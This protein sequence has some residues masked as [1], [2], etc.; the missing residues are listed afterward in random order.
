MSQATRGYPISSGSVPRGGYPISS[1]GVFNPYFDDEEE[2]D[3]AQQ[4]LRSRGII[5]DV[6]SDAPQESIWDRPASQY[7]RDI[8]DKYTEREPDDIWPTRFVK[9]FGREVEREV[10]NPLGAGLMGAAA[11]IPIAGKLGAAAKLSPGILRALKTAGKAAGPIFG[12]I[13]ITQA[14][15][16]YRQTKDVFESGFNPEETAE[17]VIPLVE[18]LGGAYLLRRAFKNRGLVDDPDDVVEQILKTSDEGT[19]VASTGTNTL[20]IRAIT[21]KYHDEISPVI[22]R[23]VDNVIPAGTGQLDILR[24][25]AIEVG[26][27][28]VFRGKGGGK[29]PTEDYINLMGQAVDNRARQVIKEARDAGMDIDESPENLLRAYN[30]ILKTKREELLDLKPTWK[31]DRMTAATVDKKQDIEIDHVKPPETTVGDVVDGTIARVTGIVKDPQSNT[32]ADRLLRRALQFKMIAHFTDTGRMPN[33]ELVKRMA[34]RIQ[35]RASNHDDYIEGL[36]K[37]IDYQ[38]FDEVMPYKPEKLPDDYDKPHMTEPLVP[39]RSLIRDETMDYVAKQW[40]GKGNAGDMLIKQIAEVEAQYHFDTKGV[41]P[42]NI[43]EYMRENIKIPKGSDS[44]ITFSHILDAENK[45]QFFE[46]AGGGILGKIFSN[47]KAKLLNQRKSSDVGFYPSPIPYNLD[48]L[49]LTSFPVKAR[50]LVKETL[51]VA[52]TRANIEPLKKGQTR[53]DLLNLAVRNTLKQIKGKSFRGIGQVRNSLNNFVNKRREELIENAP[54]W[55]PVKV[56]YTPKGDLINVYIPEAKAMEVFAYK[57]PSGKTLDYSSGYKRYEDNYKQLIDYTKYLSTGTGVSAARLREYAAKIRQ[58]MAVVRTA[59]EKGL[60]GRH[61]A[62]TVLDHLNNRIEAGILRSRIAKE[63]VDRKGRPK[64]YNPGRYDPEGEGRRI[65][66]SVMQ[67]FEQTRLE[68]TYELELKSLMDNPDLTMAEKYKAKF[69]LEQKLIRNLRSNEI[70]PT[71]EFFFSKISPLSKYTLLNDQLSRI[72]MMAQDRG[73]Y[74]GD[75]DIEGDLKL[76]IDRLQ[77]EIDKGHIKHAEE[78][79]QISADSIEGNKLAND[80]RQELDAIQRELGEIDPVMSQSWTNMEEG[81]GTDIVT[82]TKKT[83]DDI[84]A[85]GDVDFSDKDEI[86]TPEA[87]KALREVVDEVLSDA[88]IYGRGQHKWNV[89]ERIYGLTPKTSGKGAALR[90]ERRKELIAYRK[91]WTAYEASQSRKLERINKRL[92]DLR[93]GMAVSN[94][95]EK[96]R[97]PIDKLMKEGKIVYENMR[98]ARE[99]Y[100][101]IEKRQKAVDYEIEEM[102]KKNPNVSF[103]EMYMG[104]PITKIPLSGLFSPERSVKRLMSLVGGAFQGAY[105]LRNINGENLRELIYR[106]Y[107]MYTLFTSRGIAHVDRVLSG[108]GRKEADR[109]VRELGTYD[110]NQMGDEAKQLFALIQNYDENAATYAVNPGLLIKFD[111]DVS[112]GGF[113]DTSARE[114]L[115]DW[116]NIRAKQ[117]SRAKHFGNGGRNDL[118]YL[119]RNSPLGKAMADTDNEEVARSITES[120]FVTRDNDYG[121]AKKVDTLNT[122]QFLSYLSLHWIGNLAGNINTLMHAR[123]ALKGAAKVMFDRKM[124]GQEKGFKYRASRSGVIGDLHSTIG[125]EIWARKW[126]Q[127]S[128]KFIFLHHAESRER[129]WASAFGENTLETL[130]EMKKRGKLSEKA[131]RQLRDLTLEDPDNMTKLQEIHYIHARQRFAEITQGGNNPINMPPAWAGNN[132]LNLFAV[133]KRFAYQGQ[134]SF[135]KAIEQNPKRAIPMAL[136]ISPLFGEVI[137]DMKAMVTGTVRGLAEGGNPL[138]SIPKATNKELEYRIEKGTRANET[139][140]GFLGGTGPGTAMGKY[141]MSDIIPDRVV[142]NLLDA[143]FFGIL[144][145]IVL[146]AMEGEAIDPIVNSANI[147]FFTDVGL[148]GQQMMTNAAAGEN[149][150]DISTGQKRR[151][152]RRVPH[153]GLG[154]SRAFY[155]TEKQEHDSTSSQ[156]GSRQLRSRGRREIKPRQLR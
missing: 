133:F 127:V 55:G 62:M 89:L 140:T 16:A 66:G 142:A 143:W 137:G 73:L 26:L 27:E 25:D 56:M 36:R 132:I 86:Y 147:D 12:G 131:K 10:N 80:I 67:L 112:I 74:T 85:S 109:I 98:K 151:W 52:L 40:E 33:D 108:K 64:R 78:F 13:G 20:P 37:Q 138:E 148:T 119:S 125:S 7:L 107:S 68:H 14:P 11:A 35:Q 120:T 58:D 146:N 17:S 82:K 51:R 46:I 95:P 97:E 76:D 38:E 83:V 8:T 129:A 116:I 123:G 54:E 29:T 134:A 96:F 47:S 24:R 117:L 34:R 88:K 69:G 150:F 149:P 43:V 93:A 48:A 72:K 1:R 21:G 15:E 31:R 128:S 50:E 2:R 92:R 101:D 49:D 45:N 3:W 70:K 79:E 61:E 100:P 155:P 84:N 139:V 90:Q 121:F 103:D 30:Y 57:P 91:H 114:N 124:F 6:I 145:D 87:Q 44:D 144:S 71:N 42:K 60:M 154:M 106:Q 19:E 156:W 135:F 152:L 141:A 105:S 28:S 59:A 18:T 130:W 77:D 65:D 118:K 115:V 113:R 81:T 39:Y 102:K 23:A 110:E 53:E 63:F 41:Y 5:P 136:L 126:P 4:I 99:K 153:V 122:I 75:K 94:N 111:P 22:R 9:R 104:I 32:L